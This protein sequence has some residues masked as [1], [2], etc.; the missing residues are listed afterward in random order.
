MNDTNEYFF[1]LLFIRKLPTIK[2][3]CEGAIDCAFLRKLHY[4]I[5]LI[6]HW[7]SYYATYFLLVLMINHCARFKVYM[8]SVI[9]QRCNCSSVDAIEC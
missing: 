2:R 5:S 9:A 3:L 8:L 6:R 4:C 7:L 1:F